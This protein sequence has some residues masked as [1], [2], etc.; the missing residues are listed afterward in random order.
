MY[1]QTPKAG[2][3]RPKN[4]NKRA[5]I[6][7]AAQV[8]F[9]R[10]GYE[11]SSMDAIAL[12]ANVSKLTVYNH[13]TDK[14]R[15]FCAAI[16]AKCTT[17]LSQLFASPTDSAP[18][19]LRECLL[20]IAHS[21]QALVDSPESLAM[22]RLIISHAL[23]NPALSH[24]FYEATALPL[25][26]KMEQLL[27]AIHNAKQLEITQPKHA[28]EHFFSLLKGSRNLQLLVGYQ[29]ATV[30]ANVHQHIEDVVDLFIKAY[31]PN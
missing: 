26:H 2:P 27:T 9:L 15:L 10:Q 21:F 29:T 20:A 16:E 30:S 31:Q 8:L 28:A 11:G 14:E 24:L 7:D 23:S 13:F 4:L 3:G 25:I 18:D 19:N 1:K 17:Q 22:H 5:A 6:L 12:E